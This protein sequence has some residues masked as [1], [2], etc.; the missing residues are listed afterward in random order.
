MRE[1][2]RD[3]RKARKLTERVKRL[4]AGLEHHIRWLENQVDCLDRIL[5]EPT[6]EYDQG[7]RD[8]LKAAAEVFRGSWV[9]VTLR[10]T[11]NGNTIKVWHN[12]E[13]YEHRVMD[14]ANT[15]G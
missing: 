6:D 11:W 4:E 3:R 13:V 9:D 10:G 15:E 8:G 12:P 2:R 5:P 7:F 14:R 1:T